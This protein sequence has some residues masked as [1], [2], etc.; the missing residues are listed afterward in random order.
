MTT[1]RHLLTIDQLRSRPFPGRRGRSG[2]V[3]SGPGFHL[4]ELAAGE[5]FH[6]DGGAGRAAAEEQYDAEREALALLLAGRW[7]PPQRFGLWSLRRRALAGEEIPEP[8]AGLA[9]TVP[10]LYLWRV[11]ERWLALGVA[12]WGP[13]L[14]FQLLAAVTTT[15]PP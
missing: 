15:D 1:A 12:Q 13:E 14:A 7:G 6:E 9:H 8:W 11:G 2:A 3:E 5:A 4:A 10:D